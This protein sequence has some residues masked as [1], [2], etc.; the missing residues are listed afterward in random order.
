MRKAFCPTGDTVTLSATSST[1]ASAIGTG[2]ANA[3]RVVRI[4]AP[5]NNAQIVFVE[6]GNS[7]ITSTTAK[8]PILPGTIEVFHVGEFATHVAHITSTGTS[9]LYVTPGDGI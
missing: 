2:S 3:T 7:A 9:T 6:F 5:A 4:A 1:A 8:M